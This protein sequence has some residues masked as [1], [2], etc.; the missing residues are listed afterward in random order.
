M[1]ITCEINDGKAVFKLKQL[2]HIFRFNSNTHSFNMNSVYPITKRIT[3]ILLSLIIFQTN[4]CLAATPNP[5][6]DKI[7]QDA[8]SQNTRKP[9][10][11][12]SSSIL[13][14]EQESKKSSPAGEVSIRLSFF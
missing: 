3:L 14:P 9:N 7:L 12:K 11:P 6:L 13:A 10:T 2:T 8:T 4:I 5:E 1:L